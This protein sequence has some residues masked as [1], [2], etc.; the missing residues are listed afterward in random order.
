MVC[1]RVAILVKGQ[2]KTQG[3]VSELTDPRTFYEL[4]FRRAGVGKDRQLDAGDAAL[5]FP[6]GSVQGLELSEQVRDGER[7]GALSDGTWVK[8]HMMDGAGGHGRVEIGTTEA[9]RAQG[10]L[11]AARSAGLEVVRFRSVRPSLEDLFMEAVTD[12]VTGESLKPGGAVGD[13]EGA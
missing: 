7:R 1:E 2:V 9:G 8:V 3:S 11:D 10:F 4:E 5:G 12:D 13:G 6:V